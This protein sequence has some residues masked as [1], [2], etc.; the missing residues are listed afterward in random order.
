MPLSRSRPIRVYPY[1]VAKNR[2]EQ[3]ARYLQ[4]P[5][6]V[7]ADV[8]QSEAIVTIKSY[9][10]RRPPLI[11]DAERG[12]T[13]IYVLRSN[14]VSQ[15]EQ[16]LS[17]LFDLRRAPASNHS[18]DSAMQE[19]QQAIDEILNGSRSIDLAPTSAYIR[20][21]QH[22]MARQANLFSQSFGKEPRRRVRIYRS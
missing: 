12:G 18:L 16:F 2:L 1:G 3:A 8:G 6:V 5:V 21:L 9:Y 13:P 20:R 22:Q 15:M 19:T 7:T 11:E 14:T 10:R 4:V 17:E